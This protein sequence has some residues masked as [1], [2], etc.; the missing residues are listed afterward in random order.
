MWGPRDYWKFLWDGFLQED[1]LLRDLFSHKCLEV[2]WKICLPGKKS[3]LKGSLT[4]ADAKCHFQKQSILHFS[5][6]GDV[7]FFQLCCH[8][9]GPFPSPPHLLTSFF[10]MF[11]DWPG[12]TETFGWNSGTKGKFMVFGRG[13]KQLMRITNTQW[14]R[15]G[16]N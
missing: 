12:W 2:I 16:W 8:A 1:V 5:S 3:S 4:I 13:G 14:N 10:T 11:G 7:D 15:V 9:T 6:S